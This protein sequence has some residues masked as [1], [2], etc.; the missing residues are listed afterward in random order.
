MAGEPSVIRTPDQH[1]RVFVSSTLQPEL[2]DERRAVKVAIERMGLA[3]VMFE[4]GARPHP[5]R[6]VYRSY[7]AQ[8]DIFVGMYADSYGWVAPGEEISGIEDEYNLAP[9]S[10]P[11]L[12]YIKKSDNR[13]PQLKKLLAR[14]QSDDTVTYLPFVDAEEL[15]VRVVSDL[16]TLLAERFDESRFDGTTDGEDGGCRSIGPSCS[17]R[18]HHDDRP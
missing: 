6:S 15:V 1:I 4:L 18:H 11:K 14:I 13:D 5:P 2:A 3:P 10:M 16:A 8:S 7:L 12:I 9:D 17:G